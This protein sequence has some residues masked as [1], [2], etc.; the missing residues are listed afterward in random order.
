MERWILESLMCRR[1]D[2]LYVKRAQSWDGMNTWK[3]RQSRHKDHL[4][5]KDTKSWDG[6]IAWKNKWHR[7]R[8]HLYV[9][10]AHFLDGFY[11]C[12]TKRCRCRDR[13]II[14]LV[15]S[16][17]ERIL[18][19]SKKTLQVHSEDLGTGSS[20]T[21]YQQW[22]NIFWKGQLRFINGIG[23]DHLNKN[24]DKIVEKHS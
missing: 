24:T 14:K 19:A 5:F 2:H 17:D 20:E 21:T 22:R 3:N 18:V 13:M 6:I 11:T 4:Y 8:D 16:Q 9:K 15:I 10:K 7:R 1:R 12:K 23:R